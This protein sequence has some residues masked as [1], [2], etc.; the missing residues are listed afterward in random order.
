VL[1]DIAQHL[2]QHSRL[3]LSAQPGAGKSTCVPPMLS[4]QTWAQN[5]TII[6]LQPRRV[7][8]RALANYLSRQRGEKTGQSIGL[9]VRGQRLVSKQTQ[10][11]FV[12][13]GVLT[14]RLQQDPELTGVAAIVFD[15][16]HER[17][18]N[19]DLGLSLGLDIQAALRPDLRIILMSATLDG[20]RLAEWLQ[21]PWVDCEGRSYP[22]D[23]QHQGAQQA[24]IQPALLKAVEKAATLSQRGILV[25][26]PG[27]AEINRLKTTLSER[28]PQ[29]PVQTLYGELSLDL[30]AQVLNS[31]KDNEVHV[32]LATNLA[33]T[34]LTV[35]NIDVV[36]D[37]GQ[38]KKPVYDA[39]S[40]LSRLETVR[41][42]K[43][44]ADQRA[45]RAGR[46]GPGHCLRLWAQSERL[47]PFDQAE[48]KQADLREL[49]LEL[50]LWGTDAGALSWLDPPPSGHLTWA[51]S[52]L[53]LMGLLDENYR[54]TR[55]AA[56]VM[57]WGCGLRLGFMLEQA[58][59]NPDLACDLAALLAQ[60]VTPA[61]L[62]DDFA[63]SYEALLQFK[64]SKKGA[65][66]LKQVDLQSRNWRKKFK[67][68]TPQGSQPLNHSA[69]ISVLLKAYPD[70]IALKRTG[71]HDR[72]KMTNGRG[73]RLMRESTFI[74]QQALIVLNAQ[75][76]GSEGIVRSAMAVT[77]QDLK[78]HLGDRFEQREVVEVTAQGQLESRTDT[79]LGELVLRSR[80]LSNV[81]PEQINQ[82]LLKALVE[83]GT[84]ALNWSKT[85]QSF[86]SRVVFAQRYAQ[87]TDWPDFSQLALI[88]HVETWLSPWLTHIRTMA[89]LKK[90]DVLPALQSYLGYEQHK[91]LDA[92]VPV[93]IK[94]PSGRKVSIN[95][96]NTEQ[97]KIAGKLQEFFGKATHPRLMN[98][99]VPIS[100][101]LLSPAGRP[102]AI[103]QDL[104]YFW[105][106]V[107]PQV[108]KETR[109]R[110]PKHPWPED[111][112]SAQATAVTKARL[113]KQ[114]KNGI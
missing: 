33:E 31:G 69:L 77:L 113:V 20:E 42:S 63:S 9:T 59:P 82:A 10:I 103:T 65:F 97:P 24:N 19:A 86:C 88:N 40:G 60:R 99:A 25:F 55:V 12:T 109:G 30:Q 70:R 46:L 58:K 39:A 32:V 64:N 78:D 36:I 15:E 107:Y 4:A 2:Q 108:R 95:Y 8:A 100:I 74:G 13:E 49:A 67:S 38:A 105:S 23:I 22:I 90:L 110:Y 92:L 27:Q 112:L 96:Q 18:L 114:S 48:I 54:P 43:A 50:A 93:S 89:N 17:H 53:H 76:I 87:S 101:E 34:S 85:V 45:G 29:L 68:S 98:G 37:S 51:Q 41:I 91:Q 1:G 62:Q 26:L 79:C 71:Q 106:E 102:L 21:A 47:N 72:Y 104:A 52:A 61:Q 11:E 81:S 7:A 83:R 44:S 16:F 14:R 3:V 66:S 56:G 111:P 84:S 94:I 28:M 73:V 80:P 6:V 57:A 5:K 35:P 75:L